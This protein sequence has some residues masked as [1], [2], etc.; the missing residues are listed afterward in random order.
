MDNH[1]RE[2]Y[3]KLLVRLSKEAK[4]SPPNTDTLSD[5]ELLSR[6][7]VCLLKLNCIPMDNDELERYLN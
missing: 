1:K 7:N 3:E 6:I 2:E 5:Y 4:L